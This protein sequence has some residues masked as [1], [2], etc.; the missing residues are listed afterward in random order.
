[1]GNQNKPLSPFLTFGV[2]IW[3]VTGFVFFS[4]IYKIFYFLTGHRPM[5][6]EEW[7][8]VLLALGFGW[9]IRRACESIAGR[10]L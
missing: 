4:L 1:M 7:L 9:L 3:F 5:A 6:W 8:G 2:G 10:K